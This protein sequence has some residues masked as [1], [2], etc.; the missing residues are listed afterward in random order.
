MQRTSYFRAVSRELLLLLCLSIAGRPCA[1]VL[2]NEVEPA[3]TNGPDRIELYNSGSRPVELQGMRL[4][5]DGR[6]HRFEQSLLLGAREHLVLQCGGTRSATH[7]GPAFKLPR[8]GGTLLLVDRDG[9]TILDLFAWPA[10][11]SGI[12]MGRSP[13][14]ASTW[15][16]F[17]Q[18][19]PGTANPAGAVCRSIATPPLPSAPSGVYAEAFDL[20]L[21]AAEGSTLYYTLDGSSP[22]SLHALRYTGPI[23]VEAHTVVRAKAWAP[24]QLPS[25]ELVANYAIGHA[26]RDFV[27]VACAPEDLFGP[28]GIYHPG[29][30]ANHTRSGA[31]W[32]RAATI[33]FVGKQDHTGAV[34]L[35]LSGSGSRG[36]G[37]RS[38]K[39]YAR[40]A[41]DSPAQGLPMPQ[42]A[43]L[44]EGILRADASPHAFLRNLLMEQVV[45]RNALH[46]EV[47]PSTPLPLYLNGQYWGLY[48]WMPAKN[49]AWLQERSGAEAVDVLAGPALQ[50]IAGKDAH[51]RAAQMALFKGAPLDSLQ[52]MLDVESLLDLACLDLWTGRGDHD[53]NVR[54]FRPRQAG[55]R[56]RWVLFDMDLWAPANE[57]SVERMCSATLPETPFI[58][59]LLAH[60]ELHQGLL[61]RLCALQATALAPLTLLPLIDS[62]HGAHATELLADHRRWEL[63]LG[64][65][66]PLRV[67][68]ELR[69]FAQSRPAQLMR[70]LAERSGHKLRTVSIEVP[71]ASVATLLLEGLPLSSGKHELLAFDGVPLKLEAR[72][73]EG[74]ELAGWKGAQDAGDHARFDPGRSRSVRALFRPLVP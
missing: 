47:Q 38:F 58:P 21:E 10:M 74:H 36:L 3:V 30:Q 68:A 53:L 41:L 70:H 16:F 31:E 67:H 26:E 45:L 51:F 63:E 1:Q 4:T 66:D 27:A 9:S 55:G 65:P 71:E 11:R 28:S 72:V 39:V 22:D 35:R 73:A 64:N 33:Q 43:A 17:E 34:G 14:G 61:A 18:P 56:W 49:K 24:G 60:P 37:K 20:H 19:T 6:S 5:L 52:Q 44:R 42:G 50:A 32:E 25:A 54:C 40:K 48:R 13:D 8:N 62:L 57:N 23:R 46:V 59:Q 15:S 2:I 12:S 29:T 7:A 69:A